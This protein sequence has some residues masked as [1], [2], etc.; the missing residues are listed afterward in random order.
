M[1]E[2][3]SMIKQQSSHS[4]LFRSY[5][6]TRYR[7]RAVDEEGKPAFEEITRGDEQILEPV[8]QATNLASILGFYIV[9]PL[10]YQYM[11]LFIIELN[12]AEIAKIFGVPVPPSN[13]AKQEELVSFPSYVIMYQLSFQPSRY[14]VNEELDNKGNTLFK[15]N[16]SRLL[17]RQISDNDPY[18][19]E[20]FS[21]DPPQTPERQQQ[22]II[23]TPREINNPEYD[24]LIIQE[25]LLE[26][27]IDFQKD[28]LPDLKKRRIEL[29][30][31]LQGGSGSNFALMESLGVNLETLQDQLSEVDESINQV[32]R[33]KERLEIIRKQK[34]DI[35]VDHL[36]NI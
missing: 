2:Y 33:L 15:Q 21:Y 1:N 14:K 7:V 12:K 34:N 20:N 26:N 10:A 31:Q 28:K 27:E 6:A 32:Q 17:L 18:L 35:Y 3:Y 4:E 16:K 8:Y 23:P 9:N 5:W 22:L 11:A 25:E 24:D 13:E 36:K 29:Q 19:T 30:A